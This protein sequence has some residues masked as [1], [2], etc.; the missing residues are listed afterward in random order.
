MFKQRD[1][2]NIFFVMNVTCQLLK[3]QLTDFLKACHTFKNLFSL[4]FLTNLEC[5]SS[6]M[7]SHYFTDLSENEHFITYNN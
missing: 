1:L 6:N 2:C 4:S 3:L 5:Q 7:I